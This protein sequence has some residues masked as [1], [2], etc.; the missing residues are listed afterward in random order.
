MRYFPIGWLGKYA[1]SH[2]IVAKYNINN[3][4]IRPNLNI[5][6]IFRFCVCEYVLSKHVYRALMHGLG[7]AFI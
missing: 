4:M 5:F 3:M 2:N 6:I 1:V 7:L